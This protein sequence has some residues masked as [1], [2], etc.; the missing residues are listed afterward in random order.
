MADASY[1]QTSFLGG[2]W[3]PL[4][5][6]RMD[7][8]R[9][10]TGMN[11]CRNGLPIEEGSWVRRPGQRL[12]GPTRK[13]A[14]GVLREFH[15]AESHSYNLELTHGHLRFLAGAGIVQESFGTRVIDSLD[16][17][18]P[19]TVTVDAPHT[20][21]TGDEV[22]VTLAP[23]QT[24][25]ASIAALLGR[26]LEVTVTGANT[27]TIAD[28]VTGVTIDGTS[29]VLGSTELTVARIADFATP[30]QTADL[31]AINTVQDQTDL[32]LLHNAYQPYAI[33]ST[34]PETGT[35]FAVFSLGPAVFKDGP[36][37]DPPTDGTTITPGAVSGSTTLTLAGGSTRWAATDVGRF[38]RLFS[39]P[40]AWAVGTGYAVGDQVKFDGTYY[41]A[42]KANTGKQPDS[43]VVNWAISTTAAIWVWAT[44]T[45]YT[46]PTVVTATLTPVDGVT[47][48]PRT[49]ACATWRL[50]LY[51]NTTGYPTC[52][53]YHE[54]RLWLAGV[55]G[56]RLDGSVSND[57]F[58]FSPTASDG[59][60]ADNNS[61]AYVFNSKDVNKIFWMEPDTLGIICGTQA[62]EWLVQASAQNDNL[63]PTSVQAHRRTVYG[64][65]NVPPKRTGITI[66]FVQRLNKK[67]LE[68]VTTDFRGLSAHN[69]SLTGK[70]LTQPGIVELAYQREKVPTIWARDTNGALLSCTYRREQPYASE[71]PDFA[72]WARHDMHGLTVE[73]IQ[74]GPNFDGTIDALALIVK[75]A[76]DKRWSLLQTDMFDVDW[77]I[78]DAMYVDFAETPSMWEVLVGP[79]Q[80]LRL[81][82]LH[83]LAGQSVDVF[84][85]GIDAG[86]LTVAADGHL[87]IPIDGS[88]N[89]LL[90]N[91]W[92][93]SLNSTS[94]FHGLGLAIVRT[95]NSVP[96][97]PTLTGIQNFDLSPLTH[98]NGGPS[99]D[100]DGGRLFI[101]DAFD[102]KIAS[103]S[104]TSFKLLDGPVSSPNGNNGL[105]YAGDGYL[106]GWIGATNVAI[107]KRMD[108]KTFA[109]LASFG[110]ASSAMPTDATHWAYPRDVC[111]VTIN[112]A[113][114]LV[115][116]AL[117]SSQTSGQISVLSLTNP[118]FA[119]NPIVWDGAD[120]HTD[121]FL[122]V[123]CPGTAIGGRGRAWVLTSTN[124]LGGSISIGL[125]RVLISF[126]TS[127]MDKIG[128][129][130][131]ANIGTGWTHVT[132]CPG[133]MLDQTDGNIIGHFTTQALAAWSAISTYVIGDLV[134]ISGHDFVSLQNSN[135]NHTPT[136]GGTAFWTDL[137]VSGPAGET[138]IAKINVH[139]RAVM[140][141]NVI[142]N[143]LASF[144]LV[145]QSRLRHGRYNFLDGSGATAIM[146]SINT[147]TGVMTSSGS[148][149]FIAGAP[150]QQFSDDQTGNVFVNLQY[151][152]GGTVPQIGTTP[153]SFTSWAT[154][155][156]SPNPIPAAIPP[157]DGVFWTVPVAI[158]YTFTS[159]GQILRPIN[160]Q[161]AGSRNGPALAKTRRSHMFGALLFKTQGISFGTDFNFLRP[162]NLHGADD[163]TTL[164]LTT[165]YSDVL[166][167]TLDDTYSFN[168]MLCW[169]IDRPYP[170]NVSTM[171]AFLHTQDR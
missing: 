10:R 5:Q 51:S 144:Q 34:Q 130:A 94:N 75:D 106:Y 148:L 119:F 96:P 26:Q 27:F 140:W 11:V 7:D 85:G 20:W 9:Y 109:E 46:S 98:D 81:Y 97:V 72:G 28:A 16:T 133:I 24:A 56:N 32:L 83:Y 110:V 49:S 125:Y 105:M 86:T 170:A 18:N 126:G 157:S 165:L 39:E 15:F 131:P 113:T 152:S 92:L 111:T 89:P 142:T 14:P 164:P 141:S 67:V 41:Q 121:E 169:E 166:W 21:A 161:E 139:T 70:H 37:L 1:L 95:P 163:E 44:I 145:N 48:L 151:T 43:D 156:P 63:T 2:E 54:G 127:A 4:V 88:G 154:L 47:N 91:G 82:S 80:V 60:V 116:T 45:A 69:L 61:C 58:N 129:V 159:Q 78:G 160:P 66:T 79:P 118:D 68:Y 31:Q 137:G 102:G 135:T 40:A 42:L 147:A 134:S 71:P 76:N 146:R 150:S 87:D 84:A 168:S 167:D 57:P 53:T 35:D 77:T 136:I 162:G 120:H 112:R 59:T 17:G 8:P 100:W 90:T 50:G 114:Y 22:L 171:G 123:V 108:S 143:T 6:G 36:Y 23:N 19:V 99:V 62:G 52:G 73:S 107:L 155:G 149:T 93:A 13:G 122:G 115:S 25:N 153:A 55:I 158:G 65:A 124:N 12:I 74:A 104:A 3:S 64:C 29:M 117:N 30:Y 38:V 128:F 33:I 103:Y 101:G 138:R 132:T